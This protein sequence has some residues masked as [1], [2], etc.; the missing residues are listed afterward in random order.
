[1]VRLLEGLPIIA[2][3]HPMKLGGVLP[4]KFNI[5][6]GSSSTSLCRSLMQAPKGFNKGSM[7]FRIAIDPYLFDSKVGIWT[8]PPYQTIWTFSSNTLHIQGV[9]LGVID[10][11]EALSE[12]KWL[13]AWDMDTLPS[14]SSPYMLEIGGEIKLLAATRDWEVVVL[15]L[16]RKSGKEWGWRKVSTLSKHF[17]KHFH[18]ES[19]FVSLFDSRTCCTHGNLTFLCVGMQV[20]VFESQRM[21]WELGKCL[22]CTM[23]LLV[24]V[25]DFAAVPNVNT[26]SEKLKGAALMP[27]M[28]CSQKRAIAKLVLVHKY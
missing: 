19:S 16:D 17:D 9:Q 4:C 13:W 24:W 20:V 28:E 6:F 25:P 12:S 1:M 11:L 8:L 2:S 15:V 18:K 3:L 10:D 14:L 27:A 26:P 21:T 22:L 5:K 7:F 23:G